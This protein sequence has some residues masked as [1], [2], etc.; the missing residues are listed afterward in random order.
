MAAERFGRRLAMILGKRGRTTVIGAAIVMAVTLLPRGA[1]AEE[2]AMGDLRVKPG[3]AGSGFLTVPEVG[4]AG[5]RIPVTVI[6][7]ARKGR[8]LALVAGVHG[9]EYPPILALY[10]IKKLVDPKTLSGTLVLVHI[11]NLPAFQKRIIYYNPYDWKNLNRVFPGDLQGT[12]SQR[13]AAVLTREVVDRC[14]ALVDLHCGDGNEALIPYTY[15]MLSGRSEVSE[16][17][18]RMALAFG[19]PYIIIDDTRTQDPADS[20]YLGNTAVLRGRPAITT[21]SGFLGN[22]DEESIARNVRGVLGVMRLLGMIEGATE[23]VQEPV[24]IDKY[25]VVYSNH[26]GLFTPHLEMGY[27]VK[28]G[29][30]VGTVTGYLGEAL[31]EVRAPFD[32]MLL[33]IIHTPPCN[34]GEPLFEVGRLK[35]D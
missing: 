12:M 1:G 35:K 25:E 21:E 30:V 10:R 33:Y 19:I 29:Q 31:E 13:I 32:G 23:P 15:W 26:D 20:R 8:V 14:E 2:F 6:N 5:T 27:A 34:K 18:R 16:E 17:S 3:E 9:F 24:W 7:G 22:T 4:G 28:A 11:A